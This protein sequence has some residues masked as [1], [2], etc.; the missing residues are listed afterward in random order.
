MFYFL[1]YFFIVLLFYL[2]GICLFKLI[3]DDLFFVMFFGKCILMEF[4]IKW[5]WMINFYDNF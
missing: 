4:N 5:I 2:F 1:C 3:Y